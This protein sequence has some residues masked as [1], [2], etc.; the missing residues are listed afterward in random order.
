[1]LINKIDLLPYV[2]FD[3]AS[4][5]QY[6]RQINPSIKIIQV[7]ATRGDGMDKWLHWLLSQERDHA[8]QG[9]IPLQVQSNPLNSV[10]A[11][12]GKIG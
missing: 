5:I 2:N 12:A 9:W 4:C 6:A 8:D 3:V 11:E 1:M 7:S 10:E